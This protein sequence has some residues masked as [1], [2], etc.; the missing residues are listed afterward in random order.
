MRILPWL[1]LSQS[2]EDLTPLWYLGVGEGKDIRGSASIE[3]LLNPQVLAQ[4]HRTGQLPQGLVP[5]S[6]IFFLIRK[7]GSSSFWVEWEGAKARFSLLVPPS[8]QHG[9][10]FP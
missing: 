8:L 7:H 9:S 1:Y 5:F 6:H 4:P 10:L 3:G 2:N